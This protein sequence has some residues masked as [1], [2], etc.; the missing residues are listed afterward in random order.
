[1]FHTVGSDELCPPAVGTSTIVVH[2][3]ETV[4]GGG[5]TLAEEGVMLRL[6]PDVGNPEAVTRDRD[7]SL[8]AGDRHVRRRIGMAE[9]NSGLSAISGSFLAHLKGCNFGKRLISNRTESR[10]RMAY[11]SGSAEEVGIHRP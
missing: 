5:K 6:C 11:P 10:G 7:L 2:V 9:L 8:Q 4:L 1:M 3:P